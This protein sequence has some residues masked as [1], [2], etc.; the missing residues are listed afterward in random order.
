VALTLTGRGDDV[1]PLLNEA[2]RA[3]EA[4]GK[5]RRF[6]LGYASA[7]RSWRAR[8]RGDAPR[9]VELTRR[10]LSLLPAEDLAQR[11]FAAVGLGD[12]LRTTGNLAAANEAQA[13]AVEIG[14]TANHAYGTLTAMVWQARVQAERGRPRDAEDAFCRSLR[15]V[16]ERRVGLLPAAGLAHVGMGALL[17]ERNDLDG[18]ERELEEGMSLAERAR[19]VSNLVWGYV[20]LSRVKRARAEEA[21]AFYQERASSEDAAVGA[22]W[23]IDRM[24]SARLLQAQGQ[25]GEALRLLGELRDAAEAAGRA[26]ELIEI[27]ALRSLA[28][29]AGNQKGRAVDTL[30]QALVLAEPEGYVRTFVDEGPAMGDL[31]SATLEARQRGRQDTANDVPARYLAKLLVALE[32]DAAG[33]ASN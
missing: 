8:L 29:W 6:L 2:E 14:R 7:V 28:L 9:A 4:A 1:E 33:L 32:Q 30:T 31:L 13:E 16:T 18:A 12:A 26:G 27:L 11:S 10:A 25:H 20:T 17:Y 22:A 19:E 23:V 15:F 3:A 21:A 5:D 24:T